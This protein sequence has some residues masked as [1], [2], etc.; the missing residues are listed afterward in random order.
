MTH[1]TSLAL[2]GA[3]AKPYAARRTKP[4]LSAEQRSILARKAIAIRWATQFRAQALNK[5][6]PK[7]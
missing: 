6:K 4:K 2:R 3:R 1:A 5:P 7:E